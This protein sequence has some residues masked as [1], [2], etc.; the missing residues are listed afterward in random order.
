MNKKKTM[1]KKP[2]TKSAA[3][4]LSQNPSQ[5]AKPAVEN[6]EGLLA[7]SQSEQLESKHGPV[8]WKP[9]LDSYQDLRTQ[10]LGVR[11]IPIVQPA[12]PA[13]SVPGGP[14]LAAVGCARRSSFASWITRLALTIK[15]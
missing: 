2:R 15:N 7:E 8:Q 3:R 5:T 11:V 6:A 14:P 9:W 12:R 1:L 4:G 10:A 13:T